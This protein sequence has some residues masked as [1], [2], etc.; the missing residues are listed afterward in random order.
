MHF[1]AFIQVTFLET[2]VY[3]N[4][5]HDREFD[6]ERDFFFGNIVTINFRM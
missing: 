4:D 3:G 6:E 5:M 2:A 1:Y